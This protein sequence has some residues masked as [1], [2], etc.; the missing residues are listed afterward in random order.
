MLIIENTVLCLNIVD[1]EY[2]H[3]LIYIFTE[4]ARVQV[5]G[6]QLRN[7]RNST[8][9]GRISTPQ[10]KSARLTDSQEMPSLPDTGEKAKNNRWMS[11]LARATKGVKTRGQ[12][13]ENLEGLS[14]MF[15]TPPAVQMI[16]DNFPGEKHAGNWLSGLAKATI[17]PR[18]HGMPVEDLQGVPEMC[19]AQPSPNAVS[20]CNK[21]TSKKSL[22]STDEEA[23]VEIR[24]V[25][26]LDTL[27]LEA[28]EISPD[29]F[30]MHMTESLAPTKTPSLKSS[31]KDT[32]HIEIVSPIKSSC[33]PSLRSGRNQTS[34][35]AVTQ[36]AVIETGEVL[37]PTKMPSLCNSA[38]DTLT[39]QVVTSIQ[40]S[41]TPSLRS[42]RSLLCI[43]NSECSDLKLEIVQP[44]A[45]NRTPSMG[46]SAETKAVLRKSIGNPTEDR[47]CP[48]LR[49]IKS[50]RE[51]N[52]AESVEDFFVPNMFASPKPQP[53][54]YSRKSEGLQGVA[55]LLRTPDAE[56][57]STVE[58]PKLD[59]IKS[60][61]QPEKSLASPYFFGLK[62]LMKTPKICQRYVDPEEYFSADLFASP[63]QDSSQDPAQLAA[64]GRKDKKHSVR[65][66][67]PTS[68]KTK[69][70]TAERS[71]NTVSETSPRA[72]RSKRKAPVHSIEPV[73]KKVRC[74]RAT[75]KQQ[76]EGK[77][78]TRSSLKAV[79]GNT[80]VKSQKK[81]P[82]V[83]QDTPKP[84][85]FKR[86]KL[87][88]IIEVQSPLP[89][90]DDAIEITSSSSLIEETETSNEERKT[91]NAPKTRKQLNAPLRSSR[92]GNRCKTPAETP[93]EEF[94]TKKVAETCL[95]TRR[96]KNESV[97]EDSTN[98]GDSQKAP[99]KTLELKGERKGQRATRNT[100]AN[101]N[102]LNTLAPPIK[103]RKTRNQRAAIADLEE[104][105][106]NCSFIKEAVKNPAPSR[107]RSLAKTA[108]EHGQVLGKTKPTRSIGRDETLDEAADLVPENRSTRASWKQANKNKVVEKDNLAQ[109]TRGKNS[110]KEE[111]KELKTKVATKKMKHTPGA[112]SIIRTRGNS[113]HKAEGDD[114]SL[115]AKKEVRPDNS[116]KK[117]RA[118]RE[119]KRSTTNE[120]KE[121]MSTRSRKAVEDQAEFTGHLKV[122]TKRC[123]QEDARTPPPEPK[124]TR[125]RM[126]AESGLNM[127]ITRSHSQK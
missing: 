7:R 75:A 105:V 16:S 120:S 64:R 50:P 73:P 116:S 106:E 40:P 99:V 77:P 3:L 45:P 37:K 33:T 115:E 41:R 80:A 93:V 67:R 43:Q 6:V 112:R 38:E 104:E 62:T 47:K 58:S 57:E 1:E 18:K 127:R 30:E 48:G 70:T 84:F 2:F 74:T 82:E 95:E 28:M 118:R 90:F 29:K 53:K 89:S 78:E 97:I 76:I 39:V 13:V 31:G 23:M 87:D 24:N 21:R 17:V 98:T 54:R 66:I 9:L 61:M 124:R 125:A 86:T 119:L 109:S 15:T 72:T 55:R 114:A 100:K 36:R 42:A 91:G 20:D 111:V 4:I 60:M 44:I 121:T 34:K 46:S 94:T 56:D 11:S 35:S 103:T 71:G 83:I 5:D 8:S 68:S 107:A 126:Q 122:G 88:P 65:V 117:P 101:E 25:A 108:K 92:R 19:A 69:A 81:T 14:E 51:G 52:S 26:P 85:V 59:G 63:V 27:H 10:T 12:S 79:Q 32:T 123:R 110:G 49:L 22:S 96:K 102:S 113:A